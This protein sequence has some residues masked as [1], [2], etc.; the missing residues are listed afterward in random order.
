LFS[1]FFLFIFVSLCIFFSKR[2]Q[3]IAKLC[4]YVSVY[5]YCDFLS[6]LH[7]VHESR[8]I[9]IVT[10]CPTYIRYMN[11]GI[12][13]FSETAEQKSAKLARN[14]HWMVLYQICV[15]LVLIWNPTWLPGSIMC[16]PDGR[17][18][19]HDKSS[20]GLWPGELITYITQQVDSL[21]CNKV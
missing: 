13:I 4:I 1:F 16:S 6:Y 15:F 3:C 17:T 9:H 2:T 10:F 12:Y 14:V 11:Q 5:T 21:N 19:T 20:H 7:T 8:C 18:L